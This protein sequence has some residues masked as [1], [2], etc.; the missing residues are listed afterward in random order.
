MSR[1]NK[2]LGVQP[3]MRVEL[4]LRDKA[5]SGDLVIEVT[6]AT[7]GSS[8]TDVAAAIAGDDAKFQRT[9]KI[10]LKTASGDTHDWFDGSLTIAA[11]KSSTSGVIAING[12]VSS[13]TFKDGC[14]EVTLN[15]TGTWASG[16]TSTLTVSGS[17]L[18][19]TLTSKTSVDTLVA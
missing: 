18:G 10:R 4:Q 8:A 1:I 2:K 12:G 3:E 7:C 17:L 9:V 11:T 13:A 19:Y 6:P 15:Y 16:D 5:M 14:A